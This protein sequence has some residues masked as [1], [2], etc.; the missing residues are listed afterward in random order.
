MYLNCL[1][2]SRTW[3][4][5]LCFQSNRFVG[6]DKRWTSHVLPNIKMLT[7]LETWIFVDSGS[8][9]LSNIKY[10]IK[11]KCA[12]NIAGNL[13]WSP[14]FVAEPAVADR[15]IILYGLKWPKGFNGTFSNLFIHLGGVLLLSHFWTGGFQT[16]SW[17]IL[18]YRSVCDAGFSFS[19][20]PQGEFAGAAEIKG[21]G[22]AYFS[23]INTVRSA[24]MLRNRVFPYVEWMY[25]LWNSR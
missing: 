6:F 5:N 1:I 18:L 22:S 12:H 10:S 24:R 23:L 17:I 3:V 7:V 21:Q 15:H 14:T 20:L 19:R 8:G 9:E 25:P 2:V 11:P 4:Q 13:N 16:W